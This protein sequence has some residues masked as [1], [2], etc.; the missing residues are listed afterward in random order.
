[1]TYRPIEIVDTWEDWVVQ[2]NPPRFRRRTKA[3]DLGRWSNFNGLEVKVALV[4]A[5]NYDPS[6]KV[7]I[8]CSEDVYHLMLP[9]LVDEVV[10][11][12]FVLVMNARHRVLGVHQVARGT[13]TN[14]S[15]HPSD[16]L[17]VVLAA[18]AIAFILV[19]N[20][21]SG[22]AEPSNDDMA[23]TKRAKEAADVI[24]LQLLDHVVIA[25]GTFVSFAD[26]GQL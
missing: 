14:V 7:V 19:H 3:G 10:E 4:R 17:R 22:D 18:G 13:I 15:I 1:M 21:P 23:V 12:F 20:H 25:P 26:R 6:F 11:S 16:I 24:G 5:P 9:T 2:E 8:G